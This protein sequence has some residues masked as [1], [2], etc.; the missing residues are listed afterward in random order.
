[1]YTFMHRLFAMEEKSALLYESWFDTNKGKNTCPDVLRKTN[2]T[3]YLSR[4]G[5]RFSIL[6]F[7]R[8]I[9]PRR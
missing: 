1:M 9:F 5:D 4:Y 7:R 8:G 2:M 3:G 6:M